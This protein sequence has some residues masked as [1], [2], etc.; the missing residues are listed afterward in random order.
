EEGRGDGERQDLLGLSRRRERRTPRR[1]Q[2]RVLDRRRLRAAIQVIGNRDV[3]ASPFLAA[4]PDEHQAGGI[5]IRQR[6]QQDVVENAEDGGVGTDPE[7]QR[8]D[9]GQR[10]QRLPAQRA[11]GGLKNAHAAF[12]G[13]A[14]TLA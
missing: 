7:R 6:P 11:H 3:G 4:V 9:G 2:R 14:P 12:D 8:Q 10:E 5:A 1:E 13:G